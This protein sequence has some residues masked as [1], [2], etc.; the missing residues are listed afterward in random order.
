MHN[1]DSD[2]TGPDAQA[3]L[4]LRWENMSFCWFYRGMTQM[5]THSGDIT[6]SKL[7]LLPSENGITLKGKILLLLRANSFLL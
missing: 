2:Q 6:L 5:G 3:D 4:S 7:V 1:Q